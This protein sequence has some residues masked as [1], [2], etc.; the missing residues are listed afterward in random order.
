MTYTRTTLAKSFRATI[1]GMSLDRLNL[2]LKGN[3]YCRTL[4]YTSGIA[5]I[6][7]Q[8]ETIDFIHCGI[9][10]AEIRR[11]TRAEILHRHD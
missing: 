5:R 3:R 2:T 4:P 1:Q 6:D 11:L 10:R 7:A 9:I 8:L